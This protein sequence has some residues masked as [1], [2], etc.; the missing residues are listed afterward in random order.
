[1]ANYTKIT[2][3]PNKKAHSKITEEFLIE[4][5]QCEI[6]KESLTNLME[7]NV[8]ALKVKESIKCT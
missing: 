7:G 2:I 8:K 3:V 4:K 6:L 1:M 5:L